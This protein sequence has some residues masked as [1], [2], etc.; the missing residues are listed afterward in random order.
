MSTFASLPINAIKDDFSHQLANHDTLILSAPPGA[1]KS[2]CLPLWLLS[3]PFLKN[4]KIYLLQPRRLAVK[5]IATFLASQLNEKV[6]ETVGYRLRNEVKTSKNTK[7]EVITEGIL[8]QI[9]Q[10]N[11]DL[12]QTSLVVFDEFHERSIHGDFAFALTRDVQQ[13]LREDLKILLMSA[14][15]DIDY[16]TKALPDAKVITS[17]GR[18]YPITYSYNPPKQ[19]RVWREHSIA[20]IKEQMQTHQG[21]ILVFLPG[22]ADINFIANAI[23]QS[24]PDDLR[25]CPLYGALTLKQQQVAIQPCNTGMRKLVLAT[26]IAETSLTIEGV[27]MVIDC[28]FEKVAIYNNT[29]LINKLTQQVIAKDSAIQ[30]AGRAGRLMAGHC[31]RLYSKDNFERR[32][33]QAISDIQQTD[34]LPTLIEAARWG[35]SSLASLPLIELPACIKEQKSW[36]ELQSLDIVN[37]EYKLT[38]HGESVAKLPCHPR[39]AHMLL[40]AQEISQE[41][42]FLGCIITALLEEKDLLSSK[43]RDVAVGCNL[44]YRVEKIVANWPK[45]HGVM[46][47]IIKQ[48]NALA[49]SIGLFN[50][51]L[52]KEPNKDTHS[53]AQRGTSYISHDVNEAVHELPMS[54]VGLLIAFAYPE[55]IAKS[56]QKGGQFICA[57]GKGVTLNEED[58]LSTQ[59]YLVIADIMQIENSSSSASAKLL[60]KLA[61]S[62]E[63]VQIE[64]NFTSL[65]IEKEQAYIDEVS[66]RVSAKHTKKIGAITL[67]ESPLDTKL[68]VSAVSEMWSDYVLRKGLGALNWQ[69]KE[70]ALLARWRWLN[71]TYPQY[72]L[73]DVSEQAL[74]A[75][76]DTWLS[77]F[78]G[79]IKSIDKLG[80]L[81]LSDMLLGLLNYQQ[82]QILK[83][84]TPTH[85]I[86][87]TGRRCPITYSEGSVPKV[88]LPMQELYGETQT[89]SVGKVD[90]ALLENKQVIKSTA[91]LIEFL[92]PAQRPIQL[93]QDLPQFWSGSYKAVQKDMKA[94]YPKHYWPDN[95]ENAKPFNKTKR[96]LKDV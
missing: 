68:S 41:T 30:R 37:H 91:L 12:E 16:L 78:T 36:Q 94:R 47:N 74:L 62:I 38:A 23:L 28:G 10:N 72:E 21:S 33:E 52:N 49:K 73:A 3:F 56:R 39:F 60:V 51:K 5:N 29:S 31:I 57:N 7:L 58:E 89:P 84:A 2:T 87:P 69:K 59:S 77:P 19:S 26:N 17:E 4:T 55:R 92:S 40:K 79:D 46:G 75:T 64:Q 86:G 88:S 27:N 44:Q 66:G 45:A 22:I 25:I 71:S 42:A 8:T 48:A 82:Q 80:K 83:Q 32:P 34:L 15:L 18:S 54:S 76:R 1:G 9:I 63:K 43:S 65:I 24:C 6:G 14:T 93:T 20:V 70:N 85:F 50:K 81:A 96:H 53:N 61:A 35:V 11:P 90:V 13:G 95:P 67:E